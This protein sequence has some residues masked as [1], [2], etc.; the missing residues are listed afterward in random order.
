MAPSRKLTDRQVR[1]IR[2][3]LKSGEPLT[4]LARELGVDRKTLRRNVDDQERQE[5]EREERRKV[6]RSRRRD[7]SPQDRDGIGMAIPRTR[8]PP[9]RGVDPKLEW[10]SSPKNLS[11]PARAEASGLVR[12]CNPE[13]TIKRWTELADVERWEA[14]GW[15]RELPVSN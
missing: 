3:R 9:A 4:T 5:H 6:R 14:E 15:T 8:I 12:M 10:L 1:Q 2:R 13:G 11:G 7:E